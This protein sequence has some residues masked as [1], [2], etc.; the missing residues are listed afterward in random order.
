MH[1]REFLKQLPQWLL[2]RFLPVSQL[3]AL[4]ACDPAEEAGTI[5]VEPD[6]TYYTP[7]I[8]GSKSV[9]FAAIGDFGTGDGEEGDVAALIKSWAVD[10]IVTAGD[11]NYYNG[12]AE[13][14]DEHIGQFYHEFI[15]PYKGQYGRGAAELNRFF[16]AL[17]G[18]D[19]RQPN[20]QPHLDY[21]T[22]PG[23]GRYYDVRWDPVHLFILDSIDQEPDGVTRDSRQAEW[24]RTTIGRSNAPWKLVV[25]H[26]PPY[27]SGQKHGSQTHAQ[28]PFQEWGASAVISGN[29]HTYERLIVDGFPFFVNGLGGGNIYEFDEDDIA[30]GSMIRFNQDHGAM[31]IEATENSLH[32]Q[33][34]TRLD[35]VVDEY[36]LKK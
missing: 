29:D 6:L 10:F 36:I 26:D 2:Y 15:Y 1:R 8:P 17:G 14:I 22:L 19:W 9:R 30:P 7:L 21:F 5:Q 35:R 4:T 34:I 12:K 33:F 32:F 18:H 3:L 13:T 20:A 25:I 28:W 16:P 23:N 27:S 31:L 24:F 11:N